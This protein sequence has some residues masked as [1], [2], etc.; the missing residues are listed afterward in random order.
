[1]KELC[2][3]QDLDPNEKRRIFK[4]IPLDT[5]F[6]SEFEFM[7]LTENMRQKEDSPFAELLNRVRFGC[8]SLY[9][10]NK[11]K[12]RL[13]DESTTGCSIDKAVEKFIE[14]S[15]EQPGI[16]CLFPKTE[17]VN[18]F[19]ESITKRLKIG[20]RHINAIDSNFN[21]KLFQKNPNYKPR[22]KLKAKVIKKTNQTAGLET[23]LSIGIGS[24]IML[25]RNLDVNLGLVNGALGS[26]TDF[27]AISSD[28]ES[29]L[30]IKIKFD[31]I[32]KEQY[33]D[34]F[35]A[36][37]E[38]QK[39][40][41]IS[42]SQFPLSL[43]WAITI[44][45]SQGLSLSA[46]MLDLGPDIFEPGMAYVALSRARVLNKVYLIDFDPTSLYCSSN[47]VKEYQRLAKLFNTPMDDANRSNILPIGIDT[48]RSKRYQNAEKK[49]KLSNLE[50]ETSN[51]VTSAGER[52][53]NESTELIMINIHKNQKLTAYPLKL[54]NNDNSCFANS[55]LQCLLHLGQTHLDSIYSSTSEYSKIFQVYHYAMYSSPKLYNSLAL[56][57]FV[58]KNMRPN[59]YT[60]GTE[61]DAFLFYLD[62]YRRVSNV[63]Q[64]SFKFTHFIK[65][66]CTCGHE[67]L[68]EDNAARY[69]NIPLNNQNRSSPFNCSFFNN[70]FENCTNC[71]KVTQCTFN[72]HFQFPNE[73]KYVVL[74]I[75]LFSQ[76]PNS[77]KIRSKLVNYDVNNMILPTGSSNG[78]TF[79]VRA[80]IIRSGETISTGHYFAWVRG[81]NEDA[82]YKICDQAGT[83]RFVK[84]PNNLDNIVMMYLEKI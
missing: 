41:Y 66:R 83:K 77:P 84:L 63:I 51:L 37:Y 21:H 6:W 76:S 64:T 80:I 47:A 42:R 82:W 57:E 17:Q 59:H 58:G 43:A 31:N 75:Q 38:Y 70:V 35:I 23:V 36:D 28:D 2:I 48:S 56:R 61:Q 3:F 32:E 19:N 67:N 44:H 71:D 39:R 18:K 1:V 46:V 16:M 72:H 49:D 62:W 22:K 26:V 50:K 69:I 68:R 8:P 79:R 78:A 29:V 9:D 73:C 27:V 81:L 13:I 11:L 65:I 25:R 45:K 4:S 54:I 60:D 53:T 40:V 12:A 20:L 74:T 15:N 30:K 52:N 5:N 14:I 24:R 55:N 7:L 34:R 33:I 10:I